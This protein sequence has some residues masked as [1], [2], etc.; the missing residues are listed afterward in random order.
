M[1][2]LRHVSLAALML[3]IA[4][5]PAMAQDDRVTF[6]AAVGSSF[7]TI[8]T[9]FSTTAGLQLNLG[10]RTAL[11]GEFGM[12]PHAPFGD[13][14]DVAPAVDGMTAARVNAYHWNGNLKVRPVE[15][16]RLESYLTGGMGPFTADAVLRD[17]PVV[18]VTRFEDRR[19]A[20]DFATNV[21]AGVSYGLNDWIGLG[22]DY[23]TFFIHRDDSTPRVNRFSVGVMFSLR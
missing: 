20:T 11:V 16:G 3:L 6:N 15:F 9:T 5:V 2:T 14:A 17:A 23:R 7:A 1:R 22:A 13:A 8:G 21:G 10:E 12:L 18:G 4:T 19:R